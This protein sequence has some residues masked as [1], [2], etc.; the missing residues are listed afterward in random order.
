MHAMSGS[1]MSIGRPGPERHWQRLGFDRSVPRETVHK[2]AAAEVLLTDAER[3]GDERFAVGASWRRDHYLAHHGGPAA[4]PVLL[5]ETARQTAIYLSHRFFGVAHGVP[6]VL[7]GIS[8]ELFEA[9]PPVDE[10][11]LAVGLDVVCRKPAGGPRL[12]LELDA[13]VVV[14]HRSVGRA[15]VRWEPM[16]PRRYA[17]LRRRGGQG[18]GEAGPRTAPSC[19]PLPPARVGQLAERDVLLAA[20]ASAAHVWWLRLDRAQPVLFD[21]DSDHVPGM[22]LVE[23][24]R[25]AARVASADGRPGAS[26]ATLLDVTFTAFCEP[27]VPVS[28]T[29]EPAGRGAGVF[30]LRAHQAGRELASAEV[31][32]G[33]P[34]SSAVR[35]EAAC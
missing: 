22:T 28:I 24:F 31:G 20:D 7:S 17:L 19:V 6:F 11:Y 26:G 10:E 21:H 25:Q 29:A 14:R 13:D 30:T 8:V 34:E 3:L 23:A 9:L 32:H 2:T 27:D 1:G 5:A 12:R 18:P 33:V 35:L 15:R 4:D 16:E